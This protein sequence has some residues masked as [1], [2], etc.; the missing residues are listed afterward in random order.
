MLRKR[1]GEFRV[2]AAVDST[3]KSSDDV[4]LRYPAAWRV[5]QVQIT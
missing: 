3:Q 4:Q 5:E 1:P 2:V